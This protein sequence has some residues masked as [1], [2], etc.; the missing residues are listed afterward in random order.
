MACRIPNPHRETTSRLQ[1][2]S[3]R[4]VAS[5]SDGEIQLRITSGRTRIDLTETDARAWGWRETGVP[6]SEPGPFPREV[7]CGRW[8]V[9][10]VGGDK[11]VRVFER[12][13]PD[14]LVINHRPFRTAA[15]DR[16]SARP[17][18]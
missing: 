10:L 14:W 2:A 12:Q 16:D 1:V 13:D 17:V 8:L 7:I 6:R 4:P 5:A 15:R 3:S 9:G 11:H 18:Y